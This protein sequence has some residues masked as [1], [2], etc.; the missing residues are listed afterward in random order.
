MAEDEAC[1]LEIGQV[2]RLLLERGEQ[3]GLAHPGLPFE[4]DEPTSAT[5]ALEQGGQQAVDLRLTA[6]EDGAACRAGV[7]R[8]RR[9]GDPTEPERHGHAPRSGLGQ[10]SEEHT[11]ELQ[12]R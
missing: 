8:R 3:R 12:S 4:E 6:D 7:R 5:L 10:R 11:S 9:T 2:S 1:L